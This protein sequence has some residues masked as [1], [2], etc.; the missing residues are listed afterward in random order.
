MPR[1]LVLYAVLFAAFG[2][3]SP[4]LPGLLQQD[5]LAPSAIG[6][7]LAGGTAIRLL[8]GP[9]GG[10]LADRT[11]RPAAI[12]CAMTAA[13]AVLALGYG[14]ARGLALLLLVSVL[15]AAALAPLTPLADALALG[16]SRQRPEFEYGW[17]RAAGSAA[18]IAGTLAAGQCV[19]QAGLGVIIWLNA[20]LLALAAGAAWTVPNRVAGT[21]AA[22]GAPG[23]IM[24][25]LAM[26]VF[27]RLMLAA[28]LIGGSH[29]LHDGFEVIRWRSAGLSAGQASVLWSMSVAAEVAVFLFLGRRMVERLGPGRAMAL[30][31]AA[32]IVRWG[33]AARTAWF[34]AMALVE[35]LHGLTFALLHLACMDMIGRIVPARLA[36]TAQAFY[37]TVAMGAMSTV[38]TLASGSLYGRFGAASFWSMAAMCALALPVAIGIRVERPAAAVGR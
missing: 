7:V 10:R 22:P 19:A 20:G 23:A 3:A 5:G 24:A 29:A 34:P 26:P 12:L 31:A 28:S 4:F 33:V 15:H 17:V 21:R 38:V 18:F 9:A 8:A 2:V 14:P 32:G 11:G 13:A 30:A 36:A 35:P 1:F 27:R 25:L 16:S 37:A 6:V